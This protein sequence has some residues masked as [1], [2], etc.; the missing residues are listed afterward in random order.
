[1]ELLRP[2]RRPPWARI[3]E[4]CFLL[5]QMYS[6]WSGLLIKEVKIY[7]VERDKKEEGKKRRKK[8]KKRRGHLRLFW[9]V[10]FRNQLQCNLFCR[11]K[12]YGHF[13][14]MNRLSGCMDSCIWWENE[15]SNMLPLLYF[16]FLVLLQLACFSFS[17]VLHK[18][19]RRE[20]KKPNMRRF[21]SFTRNG[22]LEKLW[23]S[24]TSWGFE[25]L[26]LVGDETPVSGGIIT[27]SF[28]LVFSF[29][30]FR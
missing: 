27:L 25:L 11:R 10:R 6:R 14:S 2:E 21:L 3:S 28:S 19:G 20:G 8:V 22:G 16:F 1:M 23:D 12:W 7:T 9:E 29:L 30:I 13:I 15:W 26:S 18:R 5:I 4:V 17:L 24:G